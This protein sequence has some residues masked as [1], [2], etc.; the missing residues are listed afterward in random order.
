MVRKSTISQTPADRNRPHHRGVL[1][2]EGI[3]RSTKEAF[4][5]ACAYRGETM[6]DAVIRKMR[7][8]VGETK[9]MI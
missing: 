4:K 9:D 2:I 5:A 6:R 1:F 8:Y 3:P 7:E